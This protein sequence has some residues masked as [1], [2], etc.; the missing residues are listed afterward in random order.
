MPVLL[1]Q[2]NDKF[3]Y[4][5]HNVEAD[6]IAPWVKDYKVKLFLSHSVNMFA[7]HSAQFLVLS[8]K[9]CSFNMT[10]SWYLIFLS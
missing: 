6:Q 5:K 7:L 4:V 2:K 3:K 9:F 8:F 1:V 10:S